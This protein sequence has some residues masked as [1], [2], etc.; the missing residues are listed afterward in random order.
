[1]ARTA[2]ISV[3]VEPNIKSALERAAK[4]DDRTIA[5]YVERLIVSH[6]RERGFLSDVESDE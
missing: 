5:Q 2:A 3:R 6:L 1:M 4:A